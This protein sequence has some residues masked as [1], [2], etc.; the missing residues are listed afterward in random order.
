M[1]T[2]SERL[3]QVR[4]DR[5]RKQE[6]QDKALAAII[7]NDAREYTFQRDVLMDGE[8]RKGVFTAKYMGVSDRLRVGTMRAKLLDGAP[9][10]SVDTVTD[11]IAYMIAYLDVALVKKP[12]WWSFD[13][14]DDID[15]L[16]GI[17][18]E[19]FNFVQ[20]FRDNHRAGSNAGAGSDATSTEDVE[21]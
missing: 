7:D 21:D 1:T 15:D 16:R 5:Q 9:A 20:R 4:A 13:R 8:L 10:A 18:Q 14:L 17:Y 2:D 3:E 6:Q 12:S 19:V 11:D